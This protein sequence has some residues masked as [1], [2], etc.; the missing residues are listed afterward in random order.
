FIFL[1]SMSVYGLKKGVINKFTPTKPKSDYGKSKLEA[2]S[3]LNTLDNS[4]FK[5]AILRPPM[6]YG[7]KCKGNYQHL[8]HFAINSS[9]FHDICNLRIMILLV[10]LGIFIHWLIDI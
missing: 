10:N 8:S 1:S 5:I 2:E 6:I 7:K 4:D 9:I 3:L